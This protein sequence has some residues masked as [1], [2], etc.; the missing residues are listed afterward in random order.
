MAAMML[1]WLAARA[2]HSIHPTSKPTKSPKA[3]RV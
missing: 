1:A 2:N 3:A